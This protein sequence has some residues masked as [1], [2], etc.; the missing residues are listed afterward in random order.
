MFRH[1]PRHKKR[2]LMYFVYPP[3]VTNP[4]PTF[5]SKLYSALNLQCLSLGYLCSMSHIINCSHVSWETLCKPRS[6]V[7]GVFAYKLKICSPSMQIF[8]E[9]FVLWKNLEMKYFKFDF[10]YSIFSREKS[11]ESFRCHNDLS[12]FKIWLC[13]GIKNEKFI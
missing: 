1:S 11:L 9:Y 12:S 5:N 2:I 6:I 13:L 4:I 3:P 7:G 8:Y 10:A